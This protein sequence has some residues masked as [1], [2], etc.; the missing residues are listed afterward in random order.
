MTQPVEHW[1]R[2]HSHD[3]TVAE[4]DQH[5]RWFKPERRQGWEGLLKSFCVAKALC[6]VTDQLQ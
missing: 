3:A 2:L 6:M 4:I 5:S 1:K